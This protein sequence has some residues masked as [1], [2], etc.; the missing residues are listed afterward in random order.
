M[1]AMGLP[2]GNDADDGAK[3]PPTK[4]VLVAVNT[5]AAPCHE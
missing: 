4:T 5:D 3:A 1:A 2:I